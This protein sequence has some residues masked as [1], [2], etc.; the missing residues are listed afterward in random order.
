MDQDRPTYCVTPMKHKRMNVYVTRYMWE[1][2]NP[3]LKPTEIIYRSCGNDRCIKVGH[4]GM[5][6]K[7]RIP[8]IDWEQVW[9]RMLK[10]TKSGNNGCLLWTGSMSNNYGKTWINGV[11]TYSHSASWM[12]KNKTLDI[13]RTINGEYVNIRH[14]CHEPCCIEPSHLE[15]GT[16]SQNNLEDKISNGTILRGAKHPFVSISEQTASDIRR[17]KRQ[18]GEDRYLSRREIAE[19]FGV[20]MC[21]VKNI[22]CGHAWSYIP[23]RNGNTGRTNSDS[24]KYRI[25]RQ[26]AKNR[27]WT[28]AEFEEAGVTLYSGVS[29]TSENK[30]GDIAGIVGN[31]DDV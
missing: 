30:R 3:K 18:K 7:R 31:S 1:Q 24:S 26:N 6:M 22:D 21:I 19:R 9:E 12:V 20:S 11:W 2:S 13:P 23:D 10:Y 5:T 4:L 28:S 16:S 8:P 17:S 29:R 25:R 15:M 14:M 27:E